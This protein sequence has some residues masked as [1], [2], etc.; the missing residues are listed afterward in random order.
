[1]ARALGLQYSD[2]NLAVTAV[3]E[4]L[5]TSKLPWLLILDNCDNP[6]IDFANYIPSG[7][8]GAVLLT[9]RLIE[10]ERHASQDMRCNVTG[11]TL[12]EASDLVLKSAKVDKSQWVQK[13]SVAESMAETLGC[14]P[15]AITL[16]GAYISDR[17]CS[18]EEYSDVFARKSAQILDL[19]QKQ[20]TSD[21][22]TVYATFEVSMQYLEQ[23]E[24]D[25]KINAVSLLRV[26]AYMDRQSI[27]E[28]IFHR[29][30]RHHSGFL[31]GE[32]LEDE[33]YE[34]TT[35]TLMHANL[36][37]DGATV[38]ENVDAFRAARA[39]LCKFSLAQFDLDHDKISLHP[40]VH[41]WA[42]SRLNQEGR[43]TGFLTTSSL[44]ALSTQEMRGHMNYSFSLQRHLEACLKHYAFFDW[45]SLTRE[46]SYEMLRVL[47]CCV[48][49]L[50]VV[51]S[52]AACHWAWILLEDASQHPLVSN[53]SLVNI[54][55]LYGR[56][57]MATRRD[58]EAVT[59]LEEVAE[60]QI[61][62]TADDYFF[63]F[64]RQILAEAYINRRE[65]DKAI[66]LLEEISEVKHWHESK[67]LH[68]F[69]PSRDLA[70][71][72]ITSGRNT[73]GIDILDDLMSEFG[74]TFEAETPEV[75]KAWAWLAYAWLKEGHIGYAVE[76]LEEAIKL[77]KPTYPVDHPEL[78]NARSILAKAYLASNRTIEAIEIAEDVSKIL[79]A[80]RLHLT[81][82]QCLQAQLDLATI[83]VKSGQN[84]DAG[85]RMFKDE[86]ERNTHLGPSHLRFMDG[87][88]QLADAYCFLEDYEKARYI[89]QT[90]LQGY[91]SDGRDLHPDCIR[92]VKMLAQTVT[93]LKQDT[94]DVKLREEIEKLPTKQCL[95][96]PK[97]H[98]RRAIFE[99]FRMRIR[100]PATRAGTLMASK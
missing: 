86:L 58:I 67:Y 77:V 54:K 2:S 71:A 19:Q 46:N 34:L 32:I 38:D 61:A 59:V 64:R 9:S 52:S 10:C 16:G 81:A 53:I 100:S 95:P 69:I 6:D 74:E 18:L 31:P 56:C 80:S 30:W 7:L 4:A 48:Y 5:A 17:R 15:L 98:A 11:L 94:T 44:L 51:R 47:Y 97:R 93:S 24:D 68:R 33:I 27:S 13:R 63:F 36:F 8:R 99:V 45:N 39:I 83:Y 22:Q 25:S 49:Q 23:S 90:A 85:L 14:H 55:F 37:L 89:L 82:P 96:S 72:Y 87:Q 79:S 91:R 65:F 78:L 1:M 88:L 12:N 20:A 41:A 84:K 57:L 26:A 21:Y 60:F 35:W 73:K 76:T 75:L 92:C 3:K 70:I 29:A 62:S 66:H 28:E 40:L 43:A 42:Q 50:Y